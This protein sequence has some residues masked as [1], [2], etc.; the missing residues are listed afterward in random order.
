[1]SVN[2]GKDFESIVY[3]CIS[4][5]GD[6]YIKR[7]YDNMGGY[8][9]VCGDCDFICYK[10]PQFYMLECKS[11]HENTLAIYSP[12]PKKKYGAISNTQW[13]GMFKA[14]QYD[15]VAGVMCWWIDRDMTKFL[16]IQE[17]VKYREE[18]HKSI[19]FDYE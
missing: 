3:K 17:L 1:M 18:G 15:V 8:F 10:R 7:V 12:N 9:G 5:L 11:T 6:V 19:R 2:R 13:E 4:K 14:S 16:P